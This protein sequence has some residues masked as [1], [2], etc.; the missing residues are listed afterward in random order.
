MARYHAL[1]EAGLCQC[2]RK[3]VDRDGVYCQ[4][5]VEEHRKSN[6]FATKVR[7]AN[8]K[9]GLCSCGAETDGIHKMCLRCRQK[10][11]AAMLRYLH[12]KKGA[13]A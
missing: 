10:H 4:R 11:N 3:P 1:K 9:A 12:K 6:Y 5:C 13:T 8:R 7:R 2:C